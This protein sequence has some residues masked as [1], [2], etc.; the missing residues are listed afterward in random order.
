MVSRHLRAP[1]G[2]G[3][4]T[5]LNRTTVLSSNAAAPVKTPVLFNNLPSATYDAVLAVAEPFIFGPGECLFEQGSPHTGIYIIQ[6]GLVRSYYVSEDAREITLGFW[7]AGQYV[8]APQL[9]G[10]GHH[11]WTSVAVETSHCLW[12]PGAHLRR[13]SEQWP[14]L[15]LALIDA[16]VD[17][18]QSYCALLQLLATNS[19]RIR[20]AKLLVML[21]HAN[22]GA[23]AST[24]IRSSHSEMAHMI[25]STRQW[26][27]QTLSRFEREGLIEKKAQ[28]VIRIREAKRLATLK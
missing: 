18:A 5:A 17:K 7:A 3:S 10:G 1:R 25:G 8:G 6:D 24:D 4:P 11:V 23:D 20:L 26:V 21:A 13:L 9:F 27:S 14:D 12:L 16:L 22:S 15:A 28:G 19:M 2:M